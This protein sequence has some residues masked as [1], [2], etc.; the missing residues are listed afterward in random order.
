M[1][2]LSY[3][4]LL[5][6]KIKIAFEMSVKLFFYLIPYDDGIKMCDD[7]FQRN[8]MVLSFLQQWVTEK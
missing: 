4:F 6:S 8:S 3:Q 5:I 7:T 2:T 1:P